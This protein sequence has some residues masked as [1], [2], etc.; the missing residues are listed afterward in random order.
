MGVVFT[1]GNIFP[2]SFHLEFDCTNN[3]IEYETLLL[4]LK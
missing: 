2:F 1:S 3:M 4:G